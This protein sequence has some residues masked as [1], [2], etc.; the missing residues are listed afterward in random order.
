MVRITTASGGSL[1]ICFKHDWEWPVELSKS[2]FVRVRERV[3][4]HVPPPVAPAALSA[5]LAAPMDVVAGQLVPINLAA[6]RCPVGVERVT[7]TLR[8]LGPKNSC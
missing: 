6:P 7:R 4:H 5:A 2:S 8:T 3:A 1:L